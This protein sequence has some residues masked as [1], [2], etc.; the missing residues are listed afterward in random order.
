MLQTLHDPNTTRKESDL[1][2]KTSDPMVANML[3]IYY[4]VTTVIEVLVHG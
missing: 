4:F 2:L 3:E 1:I